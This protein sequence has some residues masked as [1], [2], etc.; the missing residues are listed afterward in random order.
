M[1]YLTT[2]NL[3]ELISDI[4]LPEK[5]QLPLEETLYCKDNFRDWSYNI[6]V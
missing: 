3:T 1:L 2:S 4:V 6:L 5:I